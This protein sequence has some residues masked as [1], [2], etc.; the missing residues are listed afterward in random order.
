MYATAISV[1]ETVPCRI[2]GDTAVPGL[3]AG[4]IHGE[5]D[6]IVSESETRHP[7][8]YT[9]AMVRDA[10]RTF[11]WR[12][13][14]V[15]EK[16]LWLAA[17][18]LLA[19]VVFLLWRGDRSWLV[20]ALSIVVLLPPLLLALVWRV[21]HRNTVGKFRNMPAPEATFVFAEDALMI[22][23]GLGSAS[24]PWSSLVE[25][26]ERPGYWMLFTS[27]AQFLTLPV[28]DLSEDDLA[29]LRQRLEKV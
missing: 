1:C 27:K 11:V 23:S 7:V 2:G 5:G 8:V 19:F 4:G 20:G 3:A 22:E 15:A 13:V 26:W 9:Q 6:R 10:V 17:S 14:V 24:I 16:G 29:R 21:H 12:R 18:A 28:A 25:A